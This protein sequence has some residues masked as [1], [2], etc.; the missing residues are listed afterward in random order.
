MDMISHLLSFVFLWRREERFLC[1]CINM[2]ISSSSWVCF[3]ERER[4]RLE[5]K[6]G[7]ENVI[8]FFFFFFFWG[9]SN[10]F[11]FFPISSLLFFLSIFSTVLCARWSGIKSLIT[12]MTKSWVDLCYVHQIYLC[13]HACFHNKLPACIL[14][15]ILCLYIGK[16][17]WINMCN[18]SSMKL[19]VPQ[20]ITLV[21]DFIR[22]SAIWS[23]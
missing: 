17:I 20:R 21:W 5:L 3:G 1:L 13:L 10:F 11:S 8:P 18:I 12:S 14:T 9:K 15:R 7:Q 4:E 23:S 6:K 16:S 19:E 22:R 2:L